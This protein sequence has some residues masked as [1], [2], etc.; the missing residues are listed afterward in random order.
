MRSPNGAW[1]T[2]CIR[3][4]SAFEENFLAGATH[5]IMD[6][7]PIFVDPAKECFRS[8]GCEIVLTPPESPKCN[9]FIERF[10]STTRREVGRNIIP[11]S[12]DALHSA[13]V[14]H[15]HYY[16]HH[17]T[18]QALPDRRMPAPRRGRYSVGDG[19]VVRHGMLGDAL[20]FY[21]RRAA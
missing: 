15:V 21:E 8:I 6:R 5:V 4:L 2:N 3:N 14:D 17:R 18:H 13:L 9:A 11:L 10:I 19:D 16:N 12:T 20:N 1:V 7:D